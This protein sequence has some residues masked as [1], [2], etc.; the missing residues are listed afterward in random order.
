MGINNSFDPFR[1]GSDLMS[2]GFGEVEFWVDFVV[3][4]GT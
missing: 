3:K 1:S 2:T 4:I